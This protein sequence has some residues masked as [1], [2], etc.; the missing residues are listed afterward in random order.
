MIS[1]AVFDLETSGLEGDHGIIL[2]GCIKS[3][4]DGRMHTIRTDDTN[5]KWK[6]GLRGDDR[7]TAKQI[8]EI[9]AKHDVLVA[10]NGNFFDL[11]YLRTRLLRWGLPRLPE[12]KLVDPWRIARNKLRLKSNSLGNIANYVGIKQEKTPLHMSVWVDAT[13][14][15]SRKAMNTIVEHCQKDVVVLEGVLNMVKPYIKILD[16]KGSGL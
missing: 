10:H 4:I 11:P 8:A 12:V 14:N 6:R 1:T 16:D 15:G 7:V 2:C 13:F 3:S 9:L 5:K